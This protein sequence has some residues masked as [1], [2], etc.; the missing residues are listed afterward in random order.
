MRLELTRAP[1]T[2]R[3]AKKGPSGGASGAGPSAARSGGSPKST[4][5]PEW[6][7][8]AIARITGRNGG[9]D[10]N[11][12]MHCLDALHGMLSKYVQGVKRENVAHIKRALFCPCLACKG[13]IR[14]H[15]QNGTFV[16]VAEEGAVLYARCSDW[17][18]CC[19]KEDFERCYMDVVEGS[20]TRPWIKLTAEKLEELE[21]QHTRKKLKT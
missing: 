10:I 11:T 8:S 13:V 5:L 1:I 4:F 12:S 2:W 6:V 15:D 3:Q 16:A 19:D 14:V 20:G 18:C 9:Y 21:S 17:T 7:Q